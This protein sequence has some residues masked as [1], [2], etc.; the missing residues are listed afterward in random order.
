MMRSLA[1]PAVRSF[2][3]WSFAVLP[4]AAVLLA[5]LL[6]PVDA[7]GQTSMFADPKAQQEGQVL[8]IILSER[9]NAQRRSDYQMRSDAS[10]GSSAQVAGSDALAGRFGADAEFS[11]A[12]NARNSSLQSDMLEGTF[13]ATITGTDDAG[14]LL[15][16]GERKLNVNGVTHIMRVSGTVRAFDVRFD[17]TIFSHQIANADIEYRQSGISRRF[18]RPGQ[19][20]RLGSLVVLGAAAVFA[21]SN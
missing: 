5:L 6:T 11:R 10:M 18:F 12:S 3:V 2:A 20:V 9:T 16:D 17:N 15:I 4:L 13:T 8:T 7:T 19:L 14:N 1:F 21:A